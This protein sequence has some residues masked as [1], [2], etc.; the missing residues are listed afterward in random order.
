MLI[1]LELIFYSIEFPAI[2]LLIN[3]PCNRKIN[4]KFRNE[5]T[6]RSSVVYVNSVLSF[7]ST[8]FQITI[9]FLQRK[10]KITV[11]ENFASRRVDARD[12]WNTIIRGDT[13][14]FLRQTFVSTGDHT[15][16]SHCPFHP[17]PS[18]TQATDTTLPQQVAVNLQSRL[19]L[20]KFN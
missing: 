19:V 9:L 1:K 14:K 20:S 13:D 17:A 15:K 2:S 7:F 5:Q 12:A 8:P 16:P 3:D 6:F 11:T 10:L 18:S 4:Y